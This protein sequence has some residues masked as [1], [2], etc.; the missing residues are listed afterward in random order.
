VVD[1]D[2]RRGVA[3]MAKGI[4]LKH[5]PEGLG[6]NALTTS[7]GDATVNGACYNDTLVEVSKLE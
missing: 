1:A 4:W 3:V 6:V 2:T 7:V 5:H